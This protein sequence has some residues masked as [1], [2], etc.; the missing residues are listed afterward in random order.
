[1]EH[2]PDPHERAPL[3]Q[4]ARGG[5]GAAAHALRGLERAP[6]G[7]RAARA[8][9]PLP[10]PLRGGL[11]GRRLPPPEAAPGPLARGAHDAA[12]RGARGGARPG[13][14]APRPRRGAARH[15]RS[16]PRAA[17]EER[18]RLRPAL[19]A[20]GGRAARARLP[21]RARRGGGRGRALPRARPLARSRGAR[22]GPHGHPRAAPRLRGRGAGPPLPVARAARVRAPGLGH[23]RAPQPRRA[24]GAHQDPQH[25]RQ[26][27]RDP[28]AGAERRAAAPA[29]P[30]APAGDRRHRAR[31]ARAPLMPRRRKEAAARPRTVF[32]PP[33]EHCWIESDAYDR[34]A[35]AAL[36]ADAPSL[37]RVA[38]DGG[39]LVPHFRAL[40]EDV[41]CLL[42]KLEPRLRPAEAVAPAAALNRTL[43]EAFHGH[44][45]L[46]HLRERTQL[47]ETQAGLGT[48]LIG[49]QVL[50]MLREE[51][52][53]PRGDL[54]DLWDLERREAELRRRG[55]ELAD[56]ERLAEEG[57]AAAR[58]VRDDAAHAARVA[59][60]RL[61][62][63]GQQVAERLREM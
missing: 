19:G 57:D 26:G 18:D 44:P 62:Q 12:A 61:R 45:L 11:S 55:E 21:R 24:R 36:I 30:D 50:A 43:L 25:P 34:S 40:L 16:P 56:V 31:D 29:R 48:L 47:D 35:F 49:E 46:E 39:T 23:A 6:R 63:K 32:I 7:R 42:F 52:L 3:P 9:R 8:P 10:A 1:P 2:H 33:D 54:L 5:G 41:F 22:A 59:E 60:A 14:R 51:T 20:G 4:R 37:A 15:D 53:L 28:L 58:R 13:G 17:C 27:R 38:E